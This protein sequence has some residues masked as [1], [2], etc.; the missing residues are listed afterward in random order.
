MSA[1]VRPVPPI[2]PSTDPGTFGDPVGDRSV[3]TV[4]GTTRS[5]RW[6]TLTAPVRPLLRRI[7]APVT[8]LGAAAVLAA[9]GCLV[10]ASLTGW[11]EFAVAA[12][13]IGILI[14]VSSLF[15]VGRSSYAVSVQLQAARVVAGQRAGGVMTTRN[16][17]ARRLLASRIELPVGGSLASFRIPSLAP[18]AESEDL[19]VIPTA[20]RAVIT[21][22]PAVSVRGDALGLLRR[23]VRWTVA[24]ELFVH[25]RTVRL[26]GAATGV[27]RDLEG[28]PTRDLSSNDVSFHALRGY[29]PGDDRRY[30]HWRTSARTGVL[31]VRQFEETRRT[32]LAVALA[33]DPAEYATTD[34]FEV[35]VSVAASLGAQALREERPVSVCV[36]GRL[37]TA[38]TGRRLLDGFAALVPDSGSGI[39]AAG[40]AAA[41]AV[42]NASVAVLVCGRFPDA[43][44]V[45]SA[46]TAFGIGIRVICVRVEHGAELRLSA[47]GAVDVATIGTLDDLPKALRRV[48][49]A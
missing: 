8:A 10:V 35:A 11:Q 16:T 14:L 13:V 27:I 49:A 48:R 6:L 20:R 36:G 19:F 1:P 37:L 23:Q 18:Q 7:T 30:V 42:P 33:A 24:Q 28:R 44:L 32:H 43:A 15:L 41:A 46:G 22:G 38:S 45:R 21:V 31:M 12:L 26:Q 9:V 25:P 34:E 5:A 40:R 2:G 47:I 17:G 4:T 29:V 3:R 39:V